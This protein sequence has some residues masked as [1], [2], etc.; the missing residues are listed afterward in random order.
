MKYY[1]ICESDTIIAGV[2]LGER[3]D[4]GD[5]VLLC[6]DLGAGKTTFTKGIA[7]A[8]SITREI[9][10]PTFTIMNE[11][12]GKNFRLCHFDAYRLKNGQEAVFSGI[13]E[14]IGD[15][16][17]V[18]VIEWWENIADILP[19]KNII[20]VRIKY[21]DEQKREIKIEFNK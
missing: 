2:E 21:T 3:L 9:V 13:M 1:C 20:F 6:G 17:T 8:L 5:V 12:Q 16:N 15:I 4:G 19:N 11:Y 7:K 10:S 18:C 14:N